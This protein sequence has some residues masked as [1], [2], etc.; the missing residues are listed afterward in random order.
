MHT[1]TPFHFIADASVTHI[2]NNPHFA[3]AAF[4]NRLERLNVSL[5]PSTPTMII[6]DTRT[7]YVNASKLI[8]TFR[9]APN[10]EYS[11]LSRQKTFTE[12]IDYTDELINDIPPPD[13]STFPNWNGRLHRLTS[14]Y[15]IH[16]SPTTIT[17]SGTYVHPDLIIH[18]LIYSNRRLAAHIS[19]MVTSILIREGYDDNITIESIA[20]E[21]ISR[22][23][24]MI[25]T[26]DETIASLIAENDELQMKVA[27]SVDT[28]EYTRM[29]LRAA[30]AERDRARLVYAL[31]EAKER[32]A[33]ITTGVDIAPRQALLVVAHYDHR[34]TMMSEQQKV[35]FEI[36]NENDVGDFSAK[37]NCDGGGTEGM[38]DSEIMKR[39]VEGT[40]RVKSKVL[41]TVLSLKGLPQKFEERF[42]EAFDS[43][44][45]MEVVKEGAKRY[46]LTYDLK[47]LL[48]AVD[49]YVGPFM[50]M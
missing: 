2:P 46:L 49:E 6:Y 35:S 19:R 32:I 1:T 44:I 37:W 16:T 50:M 13:A 3:V 47:E 4:A 45:E 25:T 42:A 10:K 41:K 28:D 38:N 5:P 15:H 39:G 14:T 36:V 40:L 23:T 48:D 22:L 18:V 26:R 24:D 33:S 31:S 43:T 7:L 9:D 30:N 27:A 29:R 21:Q 17:Y 12:Y 11:R 8:T 34:F 20:D